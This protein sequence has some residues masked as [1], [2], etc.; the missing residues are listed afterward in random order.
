MNLMLQMLDTSFGGLC[1]I[2]KRSQKPE[3]LHP[4]PAK[5]QVMQHYAFSQIT[6]PLL[7]V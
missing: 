2:I 5:P 6:Q 3:E 1:T 4:N 7:A